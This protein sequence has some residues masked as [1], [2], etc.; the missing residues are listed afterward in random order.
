MSSTARAVSLTF[1]TTAAAISIGLPRLSFTLSF[2]LLKL[3][4]R[5]ETFVLL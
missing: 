1:H 5:R 4:R 3:R 2:S